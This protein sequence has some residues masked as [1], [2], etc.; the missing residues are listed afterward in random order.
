MLEDHSQDFH[1]GGRI[2]SYRL[3]G[4]V[5]GAEHVEAGFA[6]ISA[7]EVGAGEGLALAGPIGILAYADAEEVEGAEALPGVGAVEGSGGAE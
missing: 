3:L 7:D 6:S 2:G 4:V 1:I 5:L